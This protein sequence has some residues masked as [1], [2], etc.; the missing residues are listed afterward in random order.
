M[1]TQTT[2][3]NGPQFDLSN[4]QHLAMRKLMADVYSRHANAL[5]R[6]LPTSAATYRGMGMGLESVALF[7]LA[8][9]TL[10]DL[11]N[12]LNNAMFDFNDLYL[13][14]AAA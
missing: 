13:S 3:A 9:P 1:S 5:E 6:G 11:C 4:P 8:D 10:S 2:A 14:R 12:A 7:A